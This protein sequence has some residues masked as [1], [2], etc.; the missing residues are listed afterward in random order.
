MR[1]GI[2]L[3]AQNGVLIL[4]NAFVTFTARIFRIFLPLGSRVWGYVSTSQKLTFKLKHASSCWC[5]WHFYGQESLP[6]VACFPGMIRPLNLS[7][8]FPFWPT[9]GESLQFAFKV[10][11]VIRHDSNAVYVLE[12]AASRGTQSAKRKT[13][14]RDEC[15]EKNLIKQLVACTEEM[16]NKV[17]CLHLFTYSV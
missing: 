9:E 10:P 1:P 15:G 13:Y 14:V 6:S 12:F 11:V 3:R 5:I 16:Q 8:P 2:A 4:C 7:F 17:N